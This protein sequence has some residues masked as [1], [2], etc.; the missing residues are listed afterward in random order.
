MMDSITR[1]FNLLKITP[2][3]LKYIF[4]KLFFFSFAIGTFE[5]TLTY[6]NVLTK[7]KK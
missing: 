2:R 4:W 7:F 3:Y 5:Q 1:F 6:L